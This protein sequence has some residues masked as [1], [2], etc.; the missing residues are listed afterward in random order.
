MVV[1]VVYSKFLSVSLTHKLVVVVVAMFSDMHRWRSRYYW[2]IVLHCLYDVDPSRILCARSHCK[3]GGVDYD[4]I[5]ALLYDLVVIFQ[6]W[7]CIAGCT[8]IHSQLQIDEGYG[9]KGGKGLCLKMGKK[10]LFER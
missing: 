10:V 3:R 6:S 7:H 9:S 2:I 5:L 4:W 8:V 1:Y